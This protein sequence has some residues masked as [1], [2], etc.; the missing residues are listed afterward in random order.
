MNLSNIH[1]KTFLLSLGLTAHFL[2]SSFAIAG[3]SIKDSIVKIYS[4]NNRYNYHEPW[5]MKGQSTSH[6][7]GSI[8]GG[9]RILTNAHVVSDHMFIQVRRAGQAKKYTGRVELIGHETDLAIVRVE[10]DSFFFGATPLE[11]GD[12]PELKDSVSVY[13]FPDGGDKLSLTDGIVSRVEHASYAHSGAYLLACQI[14]ASINSGNSGGPV[15]KDGKIVGVAFQS[16]Q[17]ANYNNIGY[18]VPAPVV[19]H[20]LKDIED[21][22]HDGTPD[23]GVSMQ[24]M[25]N[26]DLRKSFRMKKNQT[27]VLVSK[28]YP[29]SPA[30]GILQR[31]DVILS[32][33]DVRV[34]NDGTIEFRKGERTFFA[35]A[36]QRKQRDDVVSLKVLRAGQEETLLIQLSQSIDY[37]RLVPHRQYDVPPAYY[38][39]GGLVFEPLTASYLLEYGGNWNVNAPTDLVNYYFNGEPLN[40]RR[41][42]IVLVKVLAD[43]LNIGYHASQNVVITSVNGKHISTMNDLVHAFES[44]QGDY[45]T[46]EDTNGFLITIDR[47]KA[48]EATPGILAKYKIN[49]DRSDNLQKEQI[50]KKTAFSQ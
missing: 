3:E 49:A 13:G 23:L 14:D 27:G 35:Y 28:I 24:Q 44:Y 25:E 41:E 10:D 8:I 47:K 5:A 1:F 32:I 7:S 18:M 26:P 11:I 22:R 38:I 17:S 43:E 45:H 9:G 39:I 50:N 19:K 31:G 29:D 6:G 30:E 20:F 40:A 46:I 37:E 4:V 33:E 21:T 42:V 2:F 34:E 36:L 12:L 16:L 48:E 15:I